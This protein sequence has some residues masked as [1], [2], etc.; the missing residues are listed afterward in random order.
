MQLI[1]DVDN[2]SGAPLWIYNRRPPPPSPDRIFISEVTPTS[3]NGDPEYS[4]L[5]EGRNT[6]LKSSQLLVIC[7]LGGP[8]DQLGQWWPYLRHWSWQLASSC[9]AFSAKLAITKLVNNK[10]PAIYGRRRFISI[11]VQ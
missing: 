8:P 1:S 9:R 10:F 5:S 2:R 3:C 7:T 11:Q 4:F 6:V